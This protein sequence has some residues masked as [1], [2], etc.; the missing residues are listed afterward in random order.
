MIENFIKVDL[1]YG[2][3]VVEGLK[4]VLE[5]NSNGLIGIIE[6]EQVVKQVEQ[7]SYLFDLY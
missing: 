4:K 2:K 7:E 5:N 3:C 1:D 6:I